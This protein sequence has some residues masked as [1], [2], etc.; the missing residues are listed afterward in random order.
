MPVPRH[1][2]KAFRSKKDFKASAQR[3]HVCGESNKAVLDVH[4]IKA[5]ADGGKYRIGNAVCL[6]SNCHR[7]DHD[8]QINIQGWHNSTMGY[9]L[10]WIDAEGEEHFTTGHEQQ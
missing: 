6:C 8:G 7:L 4:R 9:V 5:G 10:H 1:L 3:C 2:H